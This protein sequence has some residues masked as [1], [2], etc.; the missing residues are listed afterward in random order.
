MKKLLYICLFICLSVNLKAQGILIVPANTIPY[1]GDLLPLGKP[2]TTLIID[3]AGNPAFIPAY[4]CVDCVDSIGITHPVVNFVPYVSKTNDVYQI[5]GRIEFSINTG[6][7]LQFFCTYTDWTNHY[8]TYTFKSD[9]N[10]F[11]SAATYI[12][13]LEIHVL[14]GTPVTFFTKVYKVGTGAISVN[15][16]KTLRLIPK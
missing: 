10:Q 12:S 4:T 2:G 13:P 11:L 8:Q 5:S 15:V 7:V 14:A 3:P 1:I 6:Y 16:S 9:G